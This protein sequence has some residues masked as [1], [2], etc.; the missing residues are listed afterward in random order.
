MVY[1]QTFLMDHKQK[2]P[3]LRLYNQGIVIFY[4][5]LKQ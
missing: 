5:Y 2:K 4:S 1:H 3:F